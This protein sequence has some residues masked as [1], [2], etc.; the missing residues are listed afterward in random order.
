MRK[1]ETINGKKSRDFFFFY[2]EPSANTN[3]NLTFNKVALK[4]IREKII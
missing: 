1:D 3:R 2:I 4:M